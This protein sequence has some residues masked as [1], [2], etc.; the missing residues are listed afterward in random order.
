MRTTRLLVGL[1]GCLILAGCTTSGAPVT[2]STAASSSSTALTVLAGV[3]PPTTA[4]PNPR[5]TGTTFDGC[6]SVTDAEAISWELDPASKVDMAGKMFTQN[7]R[8]CRWTG[9]KWFLKLYAIDGSLSQWDTLQ[10]GNDWQK[11]ITIGGR[12]GWLLHTKDQATCTVALPSQQGIA[13]VQVD[14]DLEPQRAGYDQCPLA[15]QIA[16]TV[17]PRIP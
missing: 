10:Y 4:A 17:E 2:E 11:K 7:G 13:T 8:G 9:P 1:G 3:S 12:A 14:L 5:V 16:T 15:V 6:A